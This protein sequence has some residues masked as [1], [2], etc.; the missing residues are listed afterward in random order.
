MGNV[1]ELA[2]GRLPERDRI[3][4]DSESR[5]ETGDKRKVGVGWL[6]NPCG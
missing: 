5:T 1:G 4:A 2:E 3:H 6:G